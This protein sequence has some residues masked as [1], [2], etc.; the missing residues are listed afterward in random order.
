MPASRA[1]SRKPLGDFIACPNEHLIRSLPLECRMGHYFV[2]RGDIELDELTKSGE[3]VERMKGEPRVLQRSPEASIIELENVIS[4]WA[5]TR[6][7]SSS[8]N[9]LSTAPFTF[10]LPEST[11]TIG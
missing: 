4:T 11:I 5:R 10:S 9:R 8:F 2:V 6:V 1:A 7:N 3:A